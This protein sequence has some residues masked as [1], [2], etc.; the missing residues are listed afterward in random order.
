[1]TKKSS[2]TTDAQM[3]KQVKESKNLTSTLFESREITLNISPIA[4]ISLLILLISL[5]IAWDKYRQQ[6]ICQILT[7]DYENKISWISVPEHKN[8]KDYLSLDNGA[9]VYRHIYMD[10]FEKEFNVKPLYFPVID[11]DIADFL[12]RHNL[13]ARLL[14][15]TDIK[16]DLSS[17][18]FSNS[19]TW[20]PIIEDIKFR[21]GNGTYVDDERVY[22]RWVNDIVR[23]GMF[24]SR[25]L[26]PNDHLGLYTGLLT[27][28]LD[29]VEYAWEFNYLI[30]VLD[31]NGEKV[32]VCI[33]G[34]Y[35]GNY[36]RFANHRDENH[37]GDQ[38][39]VLY[40][41]L[42][43]VLYYVKQEIKPHEQ[44]FVNYGQAYWENKQ[45]YDFK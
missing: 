3:G 41:D 36:M 32:R 4:L 23:W 45:K 2:N 18:I 8:A 19:K 13:K 30:D 39:Y 5:T 21:V 35:M 24:A 9:F 25:A 33:D 14:N 44:I 42:W 43:Y 11:P 16:Q 34:K 12:A 29:D 26:R 22:I 31:D 17:S 20:S 7:S 28:Q 6:A 27:R 1:M 37:N 15:N 10:E 40:D 38:V